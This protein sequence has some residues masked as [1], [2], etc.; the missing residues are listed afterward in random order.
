MSL[1]S[2]ENPSIKSISI[3]GC[4]WFGFALAKKLISLNYK[5]SGSTTTEDKLATL[6]SE[7][8]QPFLI[9]FSTENITADPIFFEADVLF[10][11]IPPKRNS[12]EFSEY[13]NKIKAILTAA[14]GKSKD[15]ILI[16]STSIYS[17]TNE[18]V[19]EN[20]NPVPDTDSGK[21]VLEAEKLINMPHSFCATI[22]RFAGLIGPNRNP[23]KFFAGKKEVPN[24]LAPVN[25]IHQSDAVGIA[26]AIISKKA[27]GKTYNACNPNH[28]LRRDFYTNAAKISALPEPEFVEEKQNWKI[29]ESL[30]VPKFLRYE[31]EISL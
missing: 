8:I 12:H 2:I 13:P 23:G 10:I 3:L 14:E 27:F 30:N 18:N 19:D 24:G 25:L 5:V 20:T 21:M 11:C 7:G 28:P 4:G 9:S 16:S 26:T 29:V 1:N 6:K 22:I 17:D 31:F 15:V